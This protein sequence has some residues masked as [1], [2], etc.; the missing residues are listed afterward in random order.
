METSSVCVSLNDE[1]LTELVYRGPSFIV[2]PA[3]DDV[4]LTLLCLLGR[5][6]TNN[7]LVS[8]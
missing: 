1:T 7:V 4:S 6:L 2:A 3:G 8:S 5:K